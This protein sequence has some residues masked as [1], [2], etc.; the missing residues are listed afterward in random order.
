MIKDL[1]IGPFRLSGPVLLAPMSGITDAPFR[2]L[3]LNF[4]ASLAA[5]EMTTADHRLWK[6]AK[7]LRRLD[8]TGVSGIRV[9]QIAGSEPRQMADAARFAATQ[10]AQ[11]IDINLGCPA[12]KVC[13]KLAGSALLKDEDL[14]KRILNDVVEAAR[15]P[16]T[17][18][19]R[20]GWS[21]DRRNG[22]KVAQLAEA[23]GVT[24]IAVH[25]R[26]RQCAYRGEAEYETIRAIKSAVTIPVFAN[27][28]I[29]TPQKAA[30]VL[31]LTQ[32]DGVMIGRAAHG[33]P[34]LFEQVSKFLLEKVHVEAPSIGARRDMILTH[35]DA[36]YRLYGEHIGVRV[37]RKHLTWYCRHIKNSEELRLQGVRATSSSEQVQQ[38]RKFFDRYRVQK[39]TATLEVSIS[40]ENCQWRKQKEQENHP[41][42]QT[43]RAKFN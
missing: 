12:K 2:R 28:D 25:G 16:V 39:E 6:S 40:G 22:V 15:V 14:V 41:G 21:P 29:H 13:K 32:A 10:G 4:G 42:N 27:G 36:M 20:T 23:A 9:V 33:Q 43:A 3:C 8:F 11:V 17:I 30:Q 26:T 19:M 37:A 31:Q 24:A 35:L 38:T 34:W 1:T 5:T 18:K 7:F